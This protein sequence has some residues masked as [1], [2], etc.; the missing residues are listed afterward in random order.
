MNDNSA[1]EIGTWTIEGVSVHSSTRSRIAGSYV[2][3]Y[4]S[5]LSFEGQLYICISAL[6]LGRYTV[7]TV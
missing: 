3:L 7:F 4:N 1:C 6:P 5:L 2:K